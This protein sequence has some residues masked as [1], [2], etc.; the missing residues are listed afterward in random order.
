[1]SYD[2]ERAV[3]DLRCEIQEINRHIKILELKMTV[4]WVGTLLLI[5]VGV[6]VAIIKLG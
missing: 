3:N 2:L 6:F 4:K 1:M 5:A